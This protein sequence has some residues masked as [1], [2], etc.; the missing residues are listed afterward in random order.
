MGA[1]TTIPT[2]KCRAGWARIHTRPLRRLGLILR[3]VGIHHWLAGV[4]TNQANSQCGLIIKPGQ[5]PSGLFIN[6][7]MNPRKEAIKVLSI[8]L[9]LRFNGESWKVVSNLC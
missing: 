6:P 5:Q 3:V 7:G 9:L 2:V 4:S 8:Y 1:F